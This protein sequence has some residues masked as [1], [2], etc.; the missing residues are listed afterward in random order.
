MAGHQ[1]SNRTA[2]HSVTLQQ[3]VVKQ[4]K[5]GRCHAHAS[6]RPARKSKNPI[7]RPNPKSAKRPGS[8]NKTQ[9]TNWQTSKQ[10]DQAAD[11][12]LIRQQKA[13]NASK[14][15]R[16]VSGLQRAAALQGLNPTVKPFSVALTAYKVSTAQQAHQLATCLRL[17]ALHRIPPP[18]VP[19]GLSITLKHLKHSYPTALSTAELSWYAPCLDYPKCM[20]KLPQ[21]CTSCWADTAVS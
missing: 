5:L 1:L 11:L 19:P 3:R 6:T 14:K 12:A 17:Q 18:P 13:T 4:K 15:V 2:I 7:A 20:L 21:C 8:P 16:S 10:S 9:R